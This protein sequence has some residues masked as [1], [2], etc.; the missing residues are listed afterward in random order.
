MEK[1]RSVNILTKWCT[2]NG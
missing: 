1:I 2:W